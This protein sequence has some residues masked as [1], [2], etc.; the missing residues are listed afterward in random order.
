MSWQITH[1]HRSALCLGVW[2][3]KRKTKYNPQLCNSHKTYYTV[4]ARTR[5][6][7]IRS[8]ENKP[9]VLFRM[10]L[11]CIKMQLG[12]SIR[13]FKHYDFLAWWC[14]CNVYKTYYNMLSVNSHA[15]SK[16]TEI[17]LYLTESWESLKLKLLKSKKYCPCVSQSWAWA[18]L[19]VLKGCSGVYRQPQLYISACLAHN[20]STP[21]H[22]DVPSQHA[23][24]HKDSPLEPLHMP[25]ST[26]THQSTNLAHQSANLPTHPNQLRWNSNAYSRLRYETISQQSALSFPL[27]INKTGAC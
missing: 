22:A 26:P 10:G 19:N 18:V 21:C 9:K 4:Y 8:G 12:K 25:P 17:F 16:A 27:L 14:S 23:T 5:P 15:R 13:N 20:Y 11:P 6:I 2:L 3:R 1:S 24:C 7:I